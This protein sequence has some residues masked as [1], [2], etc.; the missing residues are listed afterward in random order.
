MSSSSRASTLK[1]AVSGLISEG[2][3]AASRRRGAFQSAFKRAHPLELRK[4]EARRMRE[5]YPDRVPVVLDR[6]PHADASLPEN[7]KRKFLVPCDL[8]VGQFV[9]VVRKQTRVTPERAIFVFVA[10][11]GDGGMALPPTG[12]TI[13]EVDAMH[14][15][16]DG[17]V[18]LTY[19][20]ENTF[21]AR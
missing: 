11:G 10:T 9:H 13:S 18:Y 15:D 20:S 17:F 16:E 4:A 7:Q 21:G 8:T 2:L 12:M 6:D 5:K 14:K 19:G 3:G 1:S